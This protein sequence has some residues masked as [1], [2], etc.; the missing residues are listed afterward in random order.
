M[1]C[2]FS[3]KRPFGKDDI[4]RQAL[5]GA[6]FIASNQGY[7]SNLILQLC[8]AHYYVAKGNDYFAN[9]AR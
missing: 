1:Q 7:D 8:P 4:M 5:L 6:I 2:F 3:K 9:H